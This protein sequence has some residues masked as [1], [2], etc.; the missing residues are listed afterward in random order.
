M[1]PNTYHAQRPEDLQKLSADNEGLT[2]I[3]QLEE[4]VITSSA[5]NWGFDHLLAYR[6]LKQP[7]TSFLKPFKND[8]KNAC[9][10]CNRNKPSTQ[11]INGD[12]LNHLLRDVEP[13]ELLQTESK[14]LRDPAGHLLVAIAQASQASQANVNDDRRTQPDRNR[15]PVERPDH[16]DSSAAVFG[17]S[18]PTRRSSSP[19]RPEPSEYS[20]KIEEID[21][22]DNERFQDIPENI[23]VSLAIAILRYVLQYI[24]IQPDGQ[25]EIRARLERLRVQARIVGFDGIT[26]EDDAGVAVY[27]K[28]E[29]GWKMANP[30]MAMVEGKRAF[31][32]IHK[33][34][35][36]RSHPIVSDKVTAQYLAQAVIAW[37]ARP[38]L[39]NEGLV[40]LLFL[41]FC[42]LDLFADGCHK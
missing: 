4:S 35:A 39:L 12:M 13:S 32:Y 10:I 19:T 17:S 7:E 14:L 23:A 31:K 9:P 22:D 20:V 24:L 33:D 2:V 16:V 40:P 1:P 42:C 34:H 21:E 3:T 28:Q 11:T 38:D 18:S 15:Q 36:G 25:V 8:H 27:L 37:K 26:F 29:Y 30:F 6:L 5:S 41:L